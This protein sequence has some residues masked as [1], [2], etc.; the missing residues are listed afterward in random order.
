MNR[1]THSLYLILLSILITGCASSGY[2]ADRGNDFLDIPTLTMSGGLGARTRV[3]PFHAGLNATVLDQGLRCGVLEANAKG[4]CNPLTGYELLGIGHEGCWPSEVYLGDEVRAKM[5]SYFTDESFIPFITP[6]LRVYDPSTTNQISDLSFY[7]MI[8]HPYATQVET[9]ASFIVG[10]RIGFNIGEL[11]DFI[12][13]WTTIDIYGDDF[14]SRKRT[15]DEGEKK[16]VK[17]IKKR[18]K[19]NKEKSQDSVPPPGI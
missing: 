19:S 18:I 1:L 9:Q 7:N 2:L 11:L 13:G 8:S 10:L 17:T 4:P 6:S 15:K 16:W 14:Q 5:K 12:L 3:G